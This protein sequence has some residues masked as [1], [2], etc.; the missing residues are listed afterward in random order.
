MNKV[1]NLKPIAYIFCGLPGSGKTTWAIKQLK[2]DKQCA[3]ICWDSIR[4]MLRGFYDNYEFCTEWETLSRKITEEA[5]KTVVKSGINI[6]IDETNI[7]RS[8]RQHWIDTIHEI[9]KD[10]KII[11]VWFTE[12]E[13]NIKRRIKSSK[14]KERSTLET[15]EIWTRVITGMK[16]SFEP[17]EDDENFDE[18]ITVNDAFQH[19]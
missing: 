1:I 13:E 10:Y 7:K 19:D 12:T 6:I 2:K 15:V 4:D 16:E 11:F 17:I 14:F 3:A 8:H 9:N 5:C 18:L